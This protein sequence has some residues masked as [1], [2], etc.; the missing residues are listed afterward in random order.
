MRDQV[1]YY[2]ASLSV[3]IGLLALIIGLT[4]QAVKLA[5]P[6]CLDFTLSC[7]IPDQP[8]EKPRQPVAVPKQPA[9]AQPP[10]LKQE[11]VR[12]DP[13]QPVVATDYAAPTP[14]AAT[15]S[16]PVADHVPR[17]VA[18][19]PAS[20]VTSLP[21]ATPG[22]EE[23]M[24]PEKAQQRYLKE[25]FAYIRNLIIK[26]LTYPEIARRMEWSGR[27]LLSFVV[28]EDGTVRVLRVKESSGHPVLDNSAMETVKRVAPFPR[29]PVAAEIVMPVHFKLQ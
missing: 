23:G 24:T 19:A 15:A 16:Q 18:P 17:G 28:N 25:H 3:H 7:P 2:A 12:P 6:I 27:V 26:R 4:T 10:P 8:Q 14:T 29:P 21:P 13:P 5:P 11:Q 1:K 22:G 20:V 9:A